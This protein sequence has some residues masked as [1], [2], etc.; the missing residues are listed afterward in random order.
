M[1]EVYRWT[2]AGMERIAAIEDCA[3]GILRYCEAF[4][5]WKRESGTMQINRYEGTPL[6]TYQ[7]RPENQ[8]IQVLEA[9]DGRYMR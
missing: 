3:A 7:L 2:D 9:E 4:A 5:V 6:Q 1:L 8:M